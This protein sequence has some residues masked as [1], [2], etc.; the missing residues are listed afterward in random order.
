[1]NPYPV[2]AVITDDCGVLD[3][4]VSYNTGGSWVNVSM[5]NTSGDTWLGSIPA[6]AANTTVYYEIIATDDSANNNQS[7]VAGSFYVQDPCQ[8]DTT[9]PV[10]SHVALTDTED[11]VGP[12]TPVFDISEE[13]GIGFVLGYYRVDGGS[14]LD[15]AATLIGS[16]SYAMTIPGQP[17]G[18]VVEYS[19]LAVD[20]SPNA[21][22][23]SGAW[24]FNVIASTPPVAPLV[25]VSVLSSI[26][27][28]LSWEAVA[29]ANGY[30]VY[31]SADG[32]SSWYLLQSTTDTTQLVTVA[33]DQVRLYRVTSHND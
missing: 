28:Q 23:S 20:A 29:N 8:T 4:Y 5:S 9:A 3:A 11:A 17:G 12:Y 32:G 21:N 26:Q 27:I 7:T 33:D 10:V 24:T 15:G 2:E 6:Q 19:F 31:E 16:D 22:Q 1:V 30:H 13:C 25:S 14:W 18:S